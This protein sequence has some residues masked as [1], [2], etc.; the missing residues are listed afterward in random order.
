[1]DIDL[2]ILFCGVSLE[3]GVQLVNDAGGSYS[4]Y[5]SSY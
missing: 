4:T 5:S 1:M 3:V 2:R